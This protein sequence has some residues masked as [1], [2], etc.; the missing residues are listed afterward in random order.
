MEVFRDMGIEKRVVDVST[1]MPLELGNG[2]MCTSL[3]G[4]ELAR[5]SCYG[6][7]PHH[8]SDF[9]MASPCEMINVGQHILE[10]VLLEHAREKGAEIR[11]SNE[12][13]DI[14]QSPEGVKARIRERQTQIEYTVRARYAIGADGGRSLMAEKFGFGFEGEPGLMNMLTSWLEVDL[15]QYTAYRPAC[16]YMMAR[17]GNAY[18][19]G[20]GTLVVV[21]PFT[22]WLLNRQYPADAEPDISDKAIIE[23]ARTV[24][25]VPNLKIHVKDT[26]KWQVNNVYAT[27][28][29]RGRIFLA[30]DAA[31]RHPPASGLGSNTCIQDAYNLAWKLKLVCSGKAGDRL[32]ESYHSERQPIAK[33]IVGHAIQTLYGFAKVPEALGFQQGQSEEEGYKSLEEL[34]SDAPVAEQRRGDLRKAVDL[35]NRRSNALGLQLGQRYSGSVAVVDDGTPFPALKRDPVLHYE[36]T[37]HPGGYLPHVWVEHKT[38]A[39]S[40]LDI[41]GHGQFSLIVGIG[42]ACFV[43]AAQKV[44]KEFGIELPVYSIGYQCTYNDVR[45]DWTGVREMGDKGALLV[46]PDRH[47]A[48]R[49][50]DRPENPTEALRSAL[51]S[52]LS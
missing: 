3:T 2:V 22:E 32:L 19:V 37:T 42:G 10:K 8:M 43:A 50:M 52:I 12:L 29:R 28:N 1:R 24:L 26:S 38:Q 15:T 4:M 44:S 18:W 47:I 40:T 35:Q 51:G 49:C 41:A 13:I 23:Y 45:G 36:M 16:I 25:G 11:F 48:W 17:P 5:Y 20:S 27:E 39:M 30:G 6:A 9:A 46:R 7:G 33:Q 14:E 21:K 34:F 31:H